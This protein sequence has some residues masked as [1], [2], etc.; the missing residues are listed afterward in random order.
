MDRA[1]WRR[2]RDSNPRDQS[3][4]LPHFECG[5]FDHSATSPAVLRSVQAVPDAMI[6]NRADHPKSTRNGAGQTLVSTVA[7][8][9]AF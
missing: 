3:P 2:G 8:S 7:G 4:S 1:K 9:E 5:A 6:R